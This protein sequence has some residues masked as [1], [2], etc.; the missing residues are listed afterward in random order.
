MTKNIDDKVQETIKEELV[1]NQ[2]SI[3]ESEEDLT[4]DQFSNDEDVTPLS[5]AEDEIN[6]L[7]DKLL[8]AVAETQNVRR[9]SEKEKADAANYAMTNF[10]RDILAIGDNLSRALESLHE[11][12]ELSDNIK[13]L[14][15]GVKMTDRE[16]HNIFE[17]QGIN[18]IDPKG[19]AFNHNFHQAMFETETKDKDGTIIQVLQVGYK[20]KNRLL[21]PAM[22]GVSKG[23]PVK[24]L[25]K[26][27]KKE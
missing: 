9:R 10:A 12:E 13:T 14:I 4:D 27:N 24:S 15:D 1:N 7:R 11:N 23:T 20:I 22:V 3:N 16:L 2:D 18:K 8:R 5:V 21:R 25:K 6:D 26:D 19:E 17:R